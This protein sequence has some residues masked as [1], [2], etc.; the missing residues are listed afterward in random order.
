MAG[1]S[2]G[3]LVEYVGLMAMKRRVRAL[4]FQCRMVV[5]SESRSVLWN[6]RLLGL[7]YAQLILGKSNGPIGP[8]AKLVFNSISVMLEKVFEVS[9]RVIAFDGSYSPAHH[10][11]MGNRRPAQVS[12]SNAQV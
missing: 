8:P 4:D 9:G 11:P 1:A 5:E 6:D 7:V 2:F 10:P 12:P 3:K